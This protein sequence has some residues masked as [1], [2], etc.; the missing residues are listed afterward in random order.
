[1]KRLKKQKPRNWIECDKHVINDPS[2]KEAMKRR[3][4]DSLV[5]TNK[6]HIIYIICTLHRISVQ[7]FNGHFPDDVIRYISSLYFLAFEFN[8]KYDFDENGILYHLGTDLGQN[9]KYVHPQTLG[10]VDITPK[11]KNFIVVLL[12]KHFRILSQIPKIGI[13]VIK[14]KSMPKFSF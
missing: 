6:D 3:K 4:E 13:L 8:Y 11:K 5:C 10:Y 7:Y 14:L 1:M 9:L 12:H 2:E